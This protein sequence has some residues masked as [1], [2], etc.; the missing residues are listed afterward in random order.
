MHLQSIDQIRTGQEIRNFCLRIMDIILKEIRT[1]LS[2][3]Y[4]QAQKSTQ[5]CTYAHTNTQTQIGTRIRIYAHPSTNT[6]SHTKA[7]VHTQT[8]TQT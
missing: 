4:T 3:I 2:N 7:H 8:H 1:C 5:S 6:H